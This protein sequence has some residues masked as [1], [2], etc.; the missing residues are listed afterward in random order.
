LGFYGT[1]LSKI[2]TKQRSW[3][4]KPAPDRFKFNSGLQKT[5]DNGQLAKLAELVKGN[6]VIPFSFFCKS[7]RFALLDILL[8]KSIF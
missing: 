6:I 4:F 1:F 8:Q 3:I 5:H 7:I 2:I